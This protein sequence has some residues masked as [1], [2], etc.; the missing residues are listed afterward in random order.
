M[1]YEEEFEPTPLTLWAHY[2]LSREGEN[3][4]K[5]CCFPVRKW[6]YNDISMKR[7]ATG[8]DYAFTHF[9]DNV[10]K[11]GK[12]QPCYRNTTNWQGS[13]CIFADY[14]DG[15]SIS[16]FIQLNHYEC[17]IITSKS[18]QIAKDEKP[19]CD[20]YHVIF[21]LGLNIEDETLYKDMLY[22]AIALCGSD[23]ACSDI[24]RFFYGFSRSEVYY[25][26]GK[27]VYQDLV[28]KSKSISQNR[29]MK[30]KTQT[31]EW[32]DMD[33][34]GKQ[35]LYADLVKA[36]QFGVFDNYED[37][38]RLGMAL[39]TAGFNPDDWYN[40]MSLYKPND[41]KTLEDYQ[42]KWDSFNEDSITAG[43]L[44]F[45]IGEYQRQLEAKITGIL[46]S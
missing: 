1:N 19:A 7:C 13:D 15:L 6:I 35:F 22:S 40:L 16:D 42:Y 39:K 8:H 43:T 36:A 11:E 28:D 44:R 25:L 12:Q 37:S 38:L 46:N 31:I 24:S 26:P 32:V 10:S 2:R 33:N 45:Y 14:D 4:Y 41:S 3:I 21:P 27:L 9:R 29:E 30:I 20:R 17:Y 34:D 23:P 18:H 5:P